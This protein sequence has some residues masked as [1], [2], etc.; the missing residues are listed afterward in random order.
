MLRHRGARYWYP[1]K[2]G[3]NQ[4]QS[5]R[6]VTRTLTRGGSAEL[7]D[8][9]KPISTSARKSTGSHVKNTLRPLDE[10][11]EVAILSG[12][13]RSPACG[14]SSLTDRVLSLITR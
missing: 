11:Q 9:P 5:R 2:Y 1:Q 13:Q 4:A 14:D 3:R 7:R 8:S 12:C 10:I 6:H